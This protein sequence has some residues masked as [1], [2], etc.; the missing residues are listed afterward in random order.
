MWRIRRE[1]SS[2]SGGD[3]TALF[4]ELNYCL[5]RL[6]ASSTI[7][8]HAIADRLSINVTDLQVLNL[9]TLE[10]RLTAG[11]IAEM[12]RLTTASTTAVIDRIEKRGYVQRVRD[13]NDRRR[14]SVE[15]MAKLTKEVG[16]LFSE[17]SGSWENAKNTFDGYSSEELRTVVRF[18]DRLI[19]IDGNHNGESSGR[20]TE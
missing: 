17:T 18:L 11:Q 1:M 14:V 2:K 5:R 9:L 3:R 8:F 13:P 19:G 10:G 12:T 15:P 16:P 4:E 6:F 7:R 20:K